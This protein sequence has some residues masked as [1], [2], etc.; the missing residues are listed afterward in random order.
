MKPKSTRQEHGAY[1]HCAQ[2]GLAYLSLV[3]LW[4]GGLCYEGQ[5]DPVPACVDCCAEASFFSRSSGAR[6]TVRALSH[7]PISR[8]NDWFWSVV[9]NFWE[10]RFAIS[11]HHLRRSVPPVARDVVTKVVDRVSRVHI[12]SRWRTMI[13]SCTGTQLSGSYR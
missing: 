12:V 4:S 13:N 5:R 1:L 11:V 3:A 2:A 6:T 9:L 10:N 7:A 8:V